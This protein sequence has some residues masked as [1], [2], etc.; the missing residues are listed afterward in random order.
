MPDR[1]DAVVQLVEPALSSGPR[2]GLFGIAKPLQLPNRH[3]AVLA[4]R[5]RSKV[6]TPWLSFVPHTE[7]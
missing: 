3:D 7:T 4:L 5:E 1:V 6:L 2:H